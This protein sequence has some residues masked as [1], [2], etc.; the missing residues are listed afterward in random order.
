MIAILVPSR[1]R[2][3][4]LKR[5]IES[6][7]ATSANDLTIYIA[8]CGEE[9]DAYQKVSKEIFIVDRKLKAAFVTLPDNLPTAQKWNMLCD[10]AMKD[11]RNRL[12]MLGADDMVFSTPLWDEKLLSLYDKKPHVYHLQ[13][14]RDR[15][16]TPH[17]IM[18]REYIERMGF[19]VPP[20]FLHWNVD[21][22][23]IE[24]AKSANC[25]THLR[26]YELL[27]IKPSDQGN[28]D[29]THN[30]IRDF[31]WRERDAY[32]ADKMSFVLEQMKFKLSLATSKGK[33]A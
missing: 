29:E 20:I 11:E 31:G 26:D 33:A 1:G 6:A 3:K 4:E 15:D 18:T 21:T 17:P 10:I 9:I 12:F 2:P 13:D 24:A 14:S 7:C 5:M 30:R 23:T 8:V 16:G 22:W 32:V 19:F 27:H 25:F 28:P